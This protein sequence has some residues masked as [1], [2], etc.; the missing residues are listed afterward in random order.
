MSERVRFL[1]HHAES[2]AS[3]DTLQQI[4]AYQ[5]VVIDRLEL[6]PDGLIERRDIQ[7]AAGRWVGRK[8]GHPRRADGSRGHA[9]FVSVATR[10][11][12]FIGRLAKPDELTSTN[13]DVLERW[14]DHMRSEKGLAPLTIATES[15]HVKHFLRFMER[16]GVSLQ[17][18]SIKDIDDGM[19]QMGANR[20]YERSTTRLHA[21]ALRAFLRFAESQK[22]C[23]DGLAAA[24]A[25]PTV[26]RQE[27]LPAGPSW[28]EVQRLIAST[29]GNDL[30]DIRDHAILTILSVY[31]LRAGELLRLQLPDF[32]WAK[33]RLHV[34]HGKRTGDREWPLPISVKQVVTRYIEKVRPGSGHP[35][36][37][38]T[39]RRPF[40][41]MSLCCLTRMVRCRIRQ[42][43]I[44]TKRSGPHCLRHAC[45]SHLLAHGMSMKE[46]GDYLGHRDPEATRIYAKVDLTALREVANFD[47]GGLA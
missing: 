38:L 15:H 40:R 3:R 31:G 14:V 24:V 10:W 28:D 26:Y 44:R 9:R 12:D 19:A 27:F 30:K 36:L 37:F 8:F 18:L 21:S 5:L 1:K 33:A 41:P 20:G 22:H 13:A 39:L 42:L 25:A 11:L 17:R 34:R 43:E 45:A 7:S 6:R 2:G 23:A 16:R 32:D 46:I 4:A 47:L 29:K 35:E